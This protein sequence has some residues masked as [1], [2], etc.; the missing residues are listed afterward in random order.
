MISN[1]LGIPFPTEKDDLTPSFW[2]DEYWRYLF[3]VPILLSVLQSI[4]L[5]TLFNYE[6]PKYL[7][8]TGRDAELNRIMGKIY[9]VD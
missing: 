8:Q 9:S 4:L 2:K 1:L 3:A 7:K 6:T 5:F